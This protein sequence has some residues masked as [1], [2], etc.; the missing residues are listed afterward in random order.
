MASRIIGAAALAAA[1]VTGIVASWI[2]GTAAGERSR[3]RHGQ[4]ER[5]NERGEDQFL[6]RL[7]GVILSG[8]CCETSHEGRPARKVWVLTSGFTGHPMKK[9][10]SFVPVLCGSGEFH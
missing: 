2:I 5:R 4:G 7:H 8:Q 10:A 6:N 3:H 9:Y 1:I